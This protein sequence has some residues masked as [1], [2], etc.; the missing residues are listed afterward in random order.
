MAL[1][2][3]VGL[4]FSACFGSARLARGMAVVVGKSSHPSDEGNRTT[5]TRVNVCVM[6]ATPM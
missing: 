1:I 4:V 3:A 2:G 6:P 5:V